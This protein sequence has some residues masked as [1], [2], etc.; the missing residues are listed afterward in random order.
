[1]DEISHSILRVFDELGRDTLDLHALL[2]I[3]GGSDPARRDN[4]P[5][6]VEL[7]VRSGALEP[8]GGGDVYRRSEQGRLA[9]A[10]PRDVT[11]Y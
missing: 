4:I 8:A 10:R 7:L 5:G 6:A 2:E 9:V 11:L 1:M 3:A